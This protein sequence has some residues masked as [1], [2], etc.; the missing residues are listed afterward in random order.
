MSFNP[1]DSKLIAFGTNDTALFSV[2]SLQNVAV[3][4]LCSSEGEPR[5]PHEFMAISS[6]AY[7]RLGFRSRA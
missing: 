5:G 4:L 7:D 6:S 1:M 3:M 2:Q